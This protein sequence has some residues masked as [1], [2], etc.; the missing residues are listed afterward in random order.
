MS[1]AKEV[2][3]KEL[4]FQEEFESKEKELDSKHLDSVHQ[5]LL[6]HAEREL[7]KKLEP[8]PQIYKT[9]TSQRL[10]VLPCFLT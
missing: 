4:Q 8:K 9:S 3:E 7:Y 1:L 6:K 5:E 2:V 10:V